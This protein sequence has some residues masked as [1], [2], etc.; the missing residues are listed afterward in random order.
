[1][2][3]IQ[4]LGESIKDRR[5]MTFDVFIITYLGFK[6]EELESDEEGV[7]HRAYRLFLQRT[8]SERPASLPTIRRWFRIQSG[9]EPS[10]SQVIGIALSLHLC[11][12][13]AGLFLMKGIAEPSWQINDYTEII[14]MYCLENQLGLVQYEEMVREYRRHL[15]SD[16]EISH[17]SN[18]QWLFRQFEHLRG[19][20][21]DEFMYW[22]WEHA[23]IFKG[24][25]RTAQEYLE[26]YRQ[27]IVGYIRRDMKEQLKILLSETNYDNWRR[28]RR[29]RKRSGE[30]ETIRYYINRVM[31]S[32]KGGISED[33]SGTILE[34]SK[35]VYSDAGQ[36]TR[37]FSE[38]FSVVDTSAATDEDAG[39][40]KVIKAVTPK[41]L[42]DL[43]HIP[44]RNE[45]LFRAG[46]LLREIE[47]A[48][49][50]ESCLE[51]VREMAGSKTP[52]HNA[53]EAGEW[54]REFIREGKRRRRVIG[55]S[56]LLPMVLYVSQQRY[57]TE[58]D[59][60]MHSYNR[61]KALRI[62]RDMADATLL[63]CNMAPLDEKYFFDAVLILCYQ[64]KEMYGY[65]DV[66]E[67]L[68]HFSY[69]DKGSGF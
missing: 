33:L 40:K 14:A 50:N 56:D 67:T 13:E 3:F 12:E 22:M 16:I 30:G 65:Q 54:L 8:A 47:K 23:G 55:R 48:D 60:D 52:V 58:M 68:V 9:K 43:F 39:K 31:K 6:E 5:F 53:Q 32:G 10:R 66:I 17:E 38:L 26:K 18:T 24:Y 21:K 27:Q 19:L 49:V 1:M 61:E 7:R 15:A 2:N 4:V 63:A 25:S 41:Y 62:F 64:E 42:S 37:L 20:T 51:Q 28:Q 34:L 59:A 57:Q 69:I 11:V 29:I 36:N 46:Q 44:V 45:L 35:M